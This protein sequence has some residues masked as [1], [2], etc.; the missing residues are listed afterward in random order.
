MYLL[1]DF[2][3]ILTL[4]GATEKKG[5]HV[6]LEDMSVIKNASVIVEKDKVKWVGSLK[7]L[8]EKY[9]KKPLKELF[10]KNKT[11]LPGFV[12]CHTHTAFMGSRS[13]EF[14]LRQN[15]VSYRE[16]ANLGGGI[17]STVHA[18]RESSL[19]QIKK[20]L[21]LRIARFISQ[22][23]TTL[24]IKSGYGLDLNSEMKLLKSI[25]AQNQIRTISTFL[26]PHSLPPEFKKTADYIQNL[27]SVQL[28]KIKKLKLS[29]RADIFVEDGFFSLSDGK[30]YLEAAKRLGFELTVHAEQMS[31]TGAAR[32]GVTLGARS[33]DHLVE[34]SDSDIAAVARSQT[35]AV[36]LPT[37]DLYLKIPY[38]PARK[39]LDQG[40]RVALATDFN[41][42]TSPTQDL[43]LVGLL[44]RLEMKMTLPEV[45]AAYTI[46]AGYAL[47]L[48]DV[49][50]AI[51][52]D[53]SADLL[54]LDAN[55]TDLFY[56]VG[57]LPVSEVWSRG[58]KTYS[59]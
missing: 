9:R 7:K 49:V 10:Y 36:L 22:G 25:Q 11:L 44:A 26:G 57:C 52:P 21:R 14:E 3:E 46:N 37:S 48:E 50:G 18:V 28:P 30:N 42:G 35:T 5:R 2:K 53:R 6:G 56:S 51:L 15:G 58:R 31:Q 16:I 23:V 29:Q 8:P 41:P 33:V 27:I 24:E 54:I 19:S 59:S 40:A 43:S 4:K 32:L 34:L 1:R 20:T 45:I 17:Q 55:W 39:L 13:H 38:P 12:E 47:G